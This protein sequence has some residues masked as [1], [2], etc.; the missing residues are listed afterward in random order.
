MDRPAIRRS[1][2]DA[3]SPR[4]ALC[5]GCIENGK[6]FDSHWPDR[7]SLQLA[8]AMTDEQ[9]PFFESANGISR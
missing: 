9:Y 4:T 7:T 6:L 3:L 5:G 1:Q 8:A 2:P